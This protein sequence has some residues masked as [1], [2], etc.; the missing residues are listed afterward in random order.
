MPRKNA[1]P[2]NV[3]ISEEQVESQ[4]N[5]TEHPDAE[6]ALPDTDI[7]SEAATNNDDISKEPT[8]TIDYQ[9]LLHLI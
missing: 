6:T 1:E 3:N 5:D 2:E 9:N 8:E 7:M 4:V